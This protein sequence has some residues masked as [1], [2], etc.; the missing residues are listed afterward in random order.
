[1][2]GLKTLK[3]FVGSEVEG[4]INSDKLK[5]CTID[6]VK[7]ISIGNFSMKSTYRDPTGE[8]K[9]IVKEAVVDWIKYFFDIT[10]EDLK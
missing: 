8:E 7:S 4:D 1:M 10:E 9:R 3:D 6:W 5:E 2:S